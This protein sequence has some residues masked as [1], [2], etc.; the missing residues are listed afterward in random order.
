MTAVRAINN[1]TENDVL[2]TAAI[3][4]Q[5]SEHPLGEA[6]VRWARERK[7]PLHEYSQLRYRRERGSFVRNRAHASSSARGLF[8]KNMACRFLR[9]H[10]PKLTAVTARAKPS[11]WS[12]ATKRVLGAITLAD[13]LRAEAKEAV[14][15][16]KAQGYRVILAD[17]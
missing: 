9:T 15:D 12:G 6:I 17:R 10:F 4:E 14:N 5:H 1:A 3:A 2:Q 7:L 11:C 13:Q 16:L 8:L